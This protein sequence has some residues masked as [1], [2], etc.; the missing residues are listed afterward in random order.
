MIQYIW[1]VYLGT[2]LA[3]FFRQGVDVP[4]GLGREAAREVDLIASNHESLGCCSLFSRLVG[5]QVQGT[6]KSYKI[7]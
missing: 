5:F 3:S 1:L 7:I 6:I 2:L 4:T